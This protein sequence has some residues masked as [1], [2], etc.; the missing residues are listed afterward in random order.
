MRTYYT[1]DY[2]VLYGKARIN[3]LIIL[4]L[5]LLL[6][7][8]QKQQFYKYIIEWLVIQ[9]VSGVVGEQAFRREVYSI[10]LK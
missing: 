1:Y 9:F 10:A 2:V 7:T 6:E 4:Y 5:T 8:H 3:K